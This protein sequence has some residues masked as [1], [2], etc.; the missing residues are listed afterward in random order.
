MDI[1]KRSLMC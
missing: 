1:I